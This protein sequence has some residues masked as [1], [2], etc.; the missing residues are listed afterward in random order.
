MRSQI[1]LR[2]AWTVV[3]F[4]IASDGVIFAHGVAIGESSAGELTA[5]IDAHQPV[6]L[7]PSPFPG[8]TGWAAVEPGIASAEIDEPNNDLFLLDPGCNI[9]FEFIG[10]DPRL[11]IVTSHAWV[12]GETLDFGPPFFD[13]HLVFNIDVSGEIGTTYALQFKLRD[14]NGI[15]TNE[16]V[17]TLLFT[18]VETVCHCR[19]DL[20]VDETPSGADIQTFVTCVLESHHLI[21]HIDEACFCA[22]LDANGKLNELDIDLFVEKLLA[23]ESCLK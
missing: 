2:C 11:Q 9:Q 5:F 1:H 17:Y 18:P 8:I 19:G 23:S 22:D 12:P 16:P 20:D 7:P 6:E 21:A 13:F 4:L 14:L 3:I 10:A 15:Y